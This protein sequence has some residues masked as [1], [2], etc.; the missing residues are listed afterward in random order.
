[1][2]GGGFPL[3]EAANDIQNVLSSLTRSLR[4]YLSKEVATK[5]KVWELQLKKNNPGQL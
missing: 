4:V 1:M 5:R 3:A 2:F